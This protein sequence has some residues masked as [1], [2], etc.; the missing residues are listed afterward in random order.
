MLGGVC[1]GQLKSLRL[2]FKE[3][4]AVLSPMTSSFISDLVDSLKLRTEIYQDY[5]LEIT[6]T[7]ETWHVVIEEVIHRL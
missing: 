6:R 7:L 1:Y 5:T 2:S 3:T 4:L